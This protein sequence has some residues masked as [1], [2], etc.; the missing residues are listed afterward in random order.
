MTTKEAAELLGVS[1]RH[2]RHLIETGK[3]SAKKYGRNYWIEPEAV[4]AA[5]NRPG[6]GRPRKGKADKSGV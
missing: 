4:E 1:E 6:M 3:L 5:R 2:V